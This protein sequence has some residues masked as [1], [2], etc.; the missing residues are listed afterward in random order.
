MIGIVCGHGGL[1][2]SQAGAIKKIA[3]NICWHWCG[4]G[5]LTSLTIY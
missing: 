5:D 2:V 1:T 3:S 4:L